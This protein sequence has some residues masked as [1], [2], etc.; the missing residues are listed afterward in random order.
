M[1]HQSNLFKLIKDYLVE[2]IT[3]NFFNCVMYLRAYSNIYYFINHV[4]NHKLTSAEQ[5]GCRKVYI[6]GNFSCCQYMIGQW[7]IFTTICTFHQ[8]LFSNVYSWW[9]TS[10][11]AYQTSINALYLIQHLFAYNN[12]DD[13]FS[14]P[15]H[16]SCSDHLYYL[17]W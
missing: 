9:I 17:T 3:L 6:P 1:L 8:I 4:I 11:V 10:I 2:R 7:F 5:G 15:T 13:L 16:N 12:V 14:S